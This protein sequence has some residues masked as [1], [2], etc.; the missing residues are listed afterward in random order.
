M[1]RPLVALS[2]RLDVLS[3]RNERRDAL[4]QRWSVFLEACGLLPL[5]LP[6]HVENAAALL[7]QLQ[8]A[9]V[10]LT[11]GND[12]V[13]YGGD[14]P[15]RDATETMLI[16]WAMDNRRPLLAVCRGAQMLAHFFGTPLLRAQNHAG[17]RHPLHFSD[18]SQRVVNSYHDWCFVSVPEGF[19]VLASHADGGIEAIRHV[20][21]PITGILWHPER[22]APFDRL[23]MDLFRSHF[24][25]SA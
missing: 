16:R 11:G 24:G 25:V 10:V 2:Q 22:E 20:S 1:N 18:G 14:A 8:P 21:A 7:S 13:A 15:E 17:T 12:L 9:G 19:E 6:N 4:D 23:D 3:G 5:A